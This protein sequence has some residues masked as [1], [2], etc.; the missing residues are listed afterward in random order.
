MGCLWK[1]SMSPLASSWLIGEQLEAFLTWPHDWIGI[2]SWLDPIAVPLVTAV[3]LNFLEAGKLQLWHC[4]DIVTQRVLK[5]ERFKVSYHQFHVAWQH[6]IVEQHVKI[7][8]VDDCSLSA[9]THLLVTGW[10]CRYKGFWQQPDSLVNVANRWHMS[11]YSSDR[12]AHSIHAGNAPA[13]VKD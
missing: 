2:R 3:K 9:P 5:S 6:V 1:R 4:W 10:S 13:L 11:H 8:S 12:E 7:I